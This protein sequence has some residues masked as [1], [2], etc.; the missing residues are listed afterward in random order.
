MGKGKSS[1]PVCFEQADVHAVGMGGVDRELHSFPDDT[2]TLIGSGWFTW[3][4]KVL[5][6]GWQFQAAQYDLPRDW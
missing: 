4:G 2:S 5:A 3:S 6:Q 1:L